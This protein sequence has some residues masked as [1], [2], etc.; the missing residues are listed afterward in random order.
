M[1]SAAVS[2]A[3]P[4]NMLR[5]FVPPR[6][7]PA[8]RVDVLPGFAVPLPVGPLG[9]T[10]K[11]APLGR[12][13]NLEV[14]L[15]R[16]VGEV[17]RAQELRFRVFYEEMSAIP[18]A[19]AMVT[20]RDAD[21]FDAI[22]DHILVLDHDAPE[23][24][25]FGK[26]RPRIVGTYRVLRRSVAERHD[27]FYTES[28]FDLRRLLDAKPELEFLELGRSCVLPAW[29]G[30]RTLELLWQGIWAYVQ[31]HRIDVMVGCA[32]LEGIDPSRLALPLSFLHHHCAADAEWSVRALPER[33]TAMDRL[34][35]EAIDPRAAIR[36]LPPLVKGYVK[37]GAKI[38]DGAVVDRQFGTT[39]VFICMPVKEI[40]KRW[41]DFYGADASRRAA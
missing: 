25:H 33:W 16:T 18:D 28:E 39:D 11:E 1:N 19:W 35:K 20:R 7:L 24:K 9:G 22:C 21:A 13:G 8:G 4:T 30:K 3:S 26:T 23:A 29:R 41:V 10:F 34:S 37:L 15:A 38:G 17:K 27:G 31:R 36:A 2:T 5:R 6:R 32:S 40:S 12:I 14:R